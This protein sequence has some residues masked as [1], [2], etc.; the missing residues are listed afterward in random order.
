[1]SSIGFGETEFHL[2]NHIEMVKDVLETAVVGEAIEESADGI[3]GLHDPH[4]SRAQDRGRRSPR[5]ARPRLV[6]L[7]PLVMRP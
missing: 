2:L 3:F 6:R 5:R 1:M 4:L 7:Q